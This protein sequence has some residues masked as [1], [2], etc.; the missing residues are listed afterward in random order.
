MLSISLYLFASKPATM[1][2]MTFSS[3]DLYF[4]HFRI[5]HYFVLDFF[6]GIQCE[7][8]MLQASILNANPAPCSKSRLDSSREVIFVVRALRDSQVQ[9]MSVLLH[10][11]LR[12]DILCSW[13]YRLIEGYVWYALILGYFKW[14]PCEQPYACFGEDMDAFP[15]ECH[16]RSPTH[17]GLALVEGLRFV[18]SVH[19]ATC[20]LPLPPPPIPPLPPLPPL[21]PPLPLPRGVFKA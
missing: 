13:I 15:S 9:P 12:V 19:P 5:R 7:L 1:L 3:K 20:C 8:T 11:T 14:Y 4:L 18:G 21:P 16:L 6:H 17:K 2:A 10:S